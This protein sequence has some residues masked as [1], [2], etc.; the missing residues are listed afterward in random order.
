MA[1]ITAA[2]LHY[3][4]HGRFGFLSDFPTDPEY[5]L[6]SIAGV[7]AFFAFCVANGDVV[8]DFITYGIR[9]ILDALELIF[10][11]TPWIV[12]AA[13]IVVLTWL[14]AGIRTAVWSGAFLSYMGLLGF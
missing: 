9:L 4:L 5:R 2:M 14:T 13:I 10:V 3:S 12:I 7:E 6:S 8:F 1:I 11:K